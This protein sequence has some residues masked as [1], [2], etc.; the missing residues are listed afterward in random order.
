MV[1]VFDYFSTLVKLVK[2]TVVAFYELHGDTRPYSRL[3]P[4][5]SP[6]GNIQRSG[7]N[8]NISLSAH[9]GQFHISN[10][11]WIS[12]KT[13]EKSP[14]EWMLGALTHVKVGQARQNSSL[15]CITSKQI[16]IPNFK[17]ISEKMLE[18][19]QQNWVL[20]KDNNLCKSRSRSAKLELDLYYVKTNS[21]TKFQVNIWKDGR[22]SPE[23]WILAKGNN[24]CKSR[25]IAAKLNLVC[26]TRQIHKPKVNIWKEGREKSWELN[27]KKGQ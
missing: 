15:I 3:K 27:F 26:I 12:E 8:K 14:E 23:N 24:S 13:A 10:F 5:G 18:K 19:N 7:L 11:K 21:Y 2:T 22:E 17:S 25:S 1:K 20:T 6:G 4:P 16:H 9:V